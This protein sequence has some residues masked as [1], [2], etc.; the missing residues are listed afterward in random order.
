MQYVPDLP[1]G[2]TTYSPCICAA[3]T[4]FS[5]EFY[6]QDA[7][8][9]WGNL[10]LYV[11]SSVDFDVSRKG[12]SLTASQAHRIRLIVGNRF[13]DNPFKGKEP[14][15]LGVLLD[16][17]HELKSDGRIIL[18]DSSLDY[19]RKHMEQ[20]GIVKLDEKYFR[21]RLYGAL[22]QEKASVSKTLF[23]TIFPMLGVPD[24]VRVEL[25]QELEQKIEEAL[26]NLR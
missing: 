23:C 10:R 14:G 22:A 3:V 25:L 13:G 19:P 17:M 7:H 8:G 16:S 4:Y 21:T 1:D 6:R 2:M 26:T 12:D 15:L 9:N 11:A 5:G 20:E 24:D 18:V